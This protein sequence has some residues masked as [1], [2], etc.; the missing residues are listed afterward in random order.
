ML[1]SLQD[2]LKIPYPIENP[3]EYALAAQQMIVNSNSH[4]L[5]VEV[6]DLPS[7]IF[8]LIL[9]ANTKFAEFLESRELTDVENEGLSWLLENYPVTPGT[10]TSIEFTYSRLLPLSHLLLEALVFSFKMPLPAMVDAI[11]TLHIALV[12]RKAFDAGETDKVEVVI[13]CANREC[14]NTEFGGISSGSTF[15]SEHFGQAN[16]LF[17]VIGERFVPIE[18]TTGHSENLLENRQAETTKEPSRGSRFLRG[19]RNQ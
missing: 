17:T 14:T 9:Q 10:F 3:E 18:E 16:D 4:E 11:N 1:K 6:S 12:A 8:G 5:V 13:K 15:C 19:F 7:L 2:L